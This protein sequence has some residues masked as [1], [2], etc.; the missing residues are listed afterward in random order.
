MIIN[1]CLYNKR[2]ADPKYQDIVDEITNLM[3]MSSIQIYRS[4]TANAC[5][6]YED[7][8]AYAIAYNYDFLYWDME[9]NDHWAM[10]TV[11]GH[12]AG[13]VHYWKYRDLSLR[14]LSRKGQELYADRFA[15]YVVCYLGG[16][17]EDALSMFDHYPFI[18]TS[19]HPGELKRRVYVMKG[20][21]I[22]D[23]EIN[24][25]KYHKKQ[26]QNDLVENLL[27]GF[28]VI[29]AL[30]LIAGIGTALTKR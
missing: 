29:A 19:N 28:I 8:E 21:L 26:L 9:Y 25:E 22:A 3:G 7:D 6:T 10:I 15:G 5:A 13:H 24:P 14:P 12:E 17:L 27:Q 20:W 4:D 18:K 2:P 1:S 30:A 11:L 23:K 16:D